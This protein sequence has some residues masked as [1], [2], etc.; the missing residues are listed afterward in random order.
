MFRNIKEICGELKVFLSGR[1]PELQ[2][3]G[4]KLQM[5]PF[6]LSSF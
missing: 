2:A 1:Q 5:L 3:S 4:L 6:N